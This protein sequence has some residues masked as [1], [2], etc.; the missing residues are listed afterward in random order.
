MWKFIKIYLAKRPEIHNLNG[1]PS[2]IRLIKSKKIRWAGHVAQMEE[3]RNAYRILV[4][5]PEGKR[6][7]GKPI[8]R[9]EDNIRMGLKEMGWGDMDWIDPAQDR[10]QGRATVNTVMNFRG[11][12]KCWDIFQ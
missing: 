7:L 4:G 10:D 12:I 2:K 6:P 5:K 11:S 8:R 3:K 9:K 1:S